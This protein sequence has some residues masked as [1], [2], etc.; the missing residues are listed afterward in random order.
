M[1]MR[2]FFLEMDKAEALESF[3]GLTV[4]VFNAVRALTESQVVYNVK[5]RNVN[6]DIQ[7]PP[8]APTVQFVLR[9]LQELL[10]EPNLVI[11]NADLTFAWRRMCHSIYLYEIVRQG[12]YT[13]EIDDK[14][15]VYKAVRPVI[16]QYNPQTV[17]VAPA[18]NW[19]ITNTYVRRQ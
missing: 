16:P 12:I 13:V 1:V 15:P 9:F 19:L 3:P 4:R 11:T 7:F 5:Q 2:D 10:E 14:G 17:F 6:F 8:D 18:I